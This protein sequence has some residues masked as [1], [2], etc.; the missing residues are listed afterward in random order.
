MRHVLPLDL[1][2]AAERVTR[3]TPH[4]LWPGRAGTAGLAAV[5]DRG[6]TAPARTRLAGEMH[7]DQLIPAGLG[8]LARA[9]IRFSFLH[10]RAHMWCSVTG[11]S[12]KSKPDVRQ[13]LNDEEIPDL[14]AESSRKPSL[15]DVEFTGRPVSN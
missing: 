6:T 13:V 15:L 7:K 12:V 1:A 9:D 2:A 10:A 8:A 4:A 11:R 5:S 3:H 14:C